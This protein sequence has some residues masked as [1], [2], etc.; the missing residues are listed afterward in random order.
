VQDHEN[1]APQEVTDADGD[2]GMPGAHDTARLKVPGKVRGIRFKYLERLKWLRRPRPLPSGFCV[3]ESQPGHAAVVQAASGKSEVGAVATASA[4]RTVLGR[5]HVSQTDC[6]LEVHQGLRAARQDKIRRLAPQ[7]GFCDAEG[8]R[9]VPLDSSQALEDADRRLFRALPM[10]RQGAH[11]TL[12]LPG[13]Q[14]GS[15]S[16]PCMGMWPPRASLRYER[17]Q[18]FKLLRRTGE[19]FGTSKTLNLQD[20]P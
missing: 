3:T 8:S 15:D 6:S 10:Q 4:E 5:L 9:D 2:V 18:R 14:A 7:A 19:R 11:P 17:W 20:S 1:I 12:H 13:E 16:A